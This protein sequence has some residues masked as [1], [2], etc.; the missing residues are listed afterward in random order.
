MT[1]DDRH[2]ALYALLLRVWRYERHCMV[3]GCGRDTLVSWVFTVTGQRVR[4]NELR[5]TAEWAAR[6][7]LCCIIREAGRC[8]RI[9]VIHPYAGW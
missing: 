9:R 6:R 2:A 1:D 5:R 4:P 7:G 8:T 3:Q